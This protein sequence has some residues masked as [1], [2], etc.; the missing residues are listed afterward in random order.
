VVVD[1]IL[2]VSVGLEYTQVNP[3]ALLTIFRLCFLLD[4]L[5]CVGDHLFPVGIDS[6]IA[7]IDLF[8]ETVIKASL[9]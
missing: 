1:D 7:S 6:T 2:G 5:L 8:L 9:P 4:L 3:V